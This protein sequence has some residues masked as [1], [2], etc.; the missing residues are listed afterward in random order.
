MAK[1]PETEVDPQTLSVSDDPGAPVVYFDGAAGYGVRNGVVGV[2]LAMDRYGLVD[3]KAH[4]QVVSVGHLRC[5][6]AAAKS[7]VQVLQKALLLAEPPKGRR[8]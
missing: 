6:V 4:R 1:D 5:S 2:T 8:Q 7:L 3:G